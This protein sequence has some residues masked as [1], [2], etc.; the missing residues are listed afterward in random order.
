MHR[1]K[2]RVSNGVPRGALWHSL[3]FKK[4]GGAFRQQ[5]FCLAAGDLIGYVNF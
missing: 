2:A 1:F 3:T 4:V 5:D